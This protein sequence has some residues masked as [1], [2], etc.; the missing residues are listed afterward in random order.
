[1]C[2]DQEDEL[3][4]CLGFKCLTRWWCHFFSHFYLVAVFFGFK[5]VLFLLDIY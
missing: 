5:Y 1:M 3:V 2:F 4:M